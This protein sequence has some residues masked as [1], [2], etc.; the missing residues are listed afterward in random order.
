MIILWQMQEWA[1]HIWWF[2]VCLKCVLTQDE[3]H[4]CAKALLLDSQLPS[5]ISLFIF[6][7]SISEANP[8]NNWMRGEQAC[9]LKKN[10]KISSAK[11]LFSKSSIPRPFLYRANAHPS[12]GVVDLNSF[13][14][15]TLKFCHRGPQLPVT[16][17]C[18]PHYHNLS[19][20]S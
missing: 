4:D 15:N 7:W 12:I 14:R 10:L 2:Y 18:R 3:A 17:L 20:V 9:L 13:A 19:N 11:N 16:A 5:L 6:V 8:K 1:Q